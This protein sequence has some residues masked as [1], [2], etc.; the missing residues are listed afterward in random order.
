MPVVQPASFLVMAAVLGMSPAIAQEAEDLKTNTS[1]LL[2]H[3]ATDSI[4]D[5][6]RIELYHLDRPPEDHGPDRPLF[7]IASSEVSFVVKSHRTV[8][9]KECEAIVKAWR[10]LRIPQAPGGALCHTPP[11][12]IRFYRGDQLLFE[13]TI[14]WECHNFYLATIDPTSGAVRLSLQSI[15][16][17]ERRLFRAL[18][19]V[20]PV[21]SKNK[22]R[23]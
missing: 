2:M 12:G 19:A 20:L 6:D 14:C 16:D 11:Y 4:P 23:E 7:A 3:A 10:R 8:R 21:E 13:T 22:S 1:R 18:H 17:K 5:A 15:E 9:G